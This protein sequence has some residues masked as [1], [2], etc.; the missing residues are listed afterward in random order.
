MPIGLTAADLSQVRESQLSPPGSGGLLLSLHLWQRFLDKGLRQF[1]EVY[2]LGQLPSGPDGQMFDCLVGIYAGIETRFL[3]TP[4]TGN[5]VGVEVFPDEQ[6]DPC[7]LLF[8]DIADLAEQSVAKRWQVFHSGKLFADLRVEELTGAKHLFSP[9]SAAPET[10]P[11]PPTPA[12]EPTRQA[13]RDAQRKVVKIYGAGGLR[14]ME[15]YQSGILVSPQGHVLSMLSYVL[16][17]DDL[18][19]ILDDGRKFS[20][21]FIRSDPVR[22]IAIL[23]LQA[24]EETLPYFDLHKAIEAE[25]GQRV[26][27]LSNLYGIATGDEAVSVLQGVV[28]ATAPLAARRGAY[29]ANY[30]G[31]VY[32]LD[33]FA[34]NPGAAGGALVDWQGQL[35]G[36]LGKELR[37]QVTGTW[38]N[39]ALPTQALAGP[40]DDILS[41][42]TPVSAE[43]PQFTPEEPI[44]TEILGLRL[45]PNVLPRTP[46]YLD[47][48][49]RGSAADLAGLRPD[50][51]IIFVEQ[52]P[53]GS[54]QE[55]IAWLARHESEEQLS[56]SVLREGELL[57]FE[58]QFDSPQP[59]LDETKEIAT[60]AE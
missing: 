35:L 38:L 34:N 49:R 46:P 43:V 39:Y 17:T 9:E 13:V 56:L 28:T 15:A 12:T 33:A 4:G 55:F 22:D 44:S 5:F 29:Q 32:V 26:M 1:G 2:Y 41:G 36:M 54:C 10:T 31:E 40:V 16:D 45:V 6:H 25:T 59:A 11:Q 51:L 52:Q 8:S 48:V 30:R 57:E 18:V 21:E 37:S 24:E 27:A 3:F 53:V 42:R 23:R 50:D 14:E 20:L 60:E 19:A 58:I 47:S 7:L